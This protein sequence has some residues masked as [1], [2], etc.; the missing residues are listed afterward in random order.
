MTTA[1][2]TEAELTAFVGSAVSDGARLLER[3][4]ELVDSH[5]VATYDVDSS[6]D[7]PTDTDVAA[8]LRD[9]TCAQVEFWVEVGEDHDISGMAGRDVSIGRLSIDKLPDELAPRARRFLA[10]AG[11]LHPIQAAAWPAAV[12]DWS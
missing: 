1:Y 10:N 12:G 7:L 4:S 5:V 3:A 11:L 2:A 6:T 9:A 8:A